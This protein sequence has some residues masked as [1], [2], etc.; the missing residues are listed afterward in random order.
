M[1]RY[2]SNVIFIRYQ[3]ISFQLVA[4]Y[5]FCVTLP[6]LDN[7]I[8]KPINIKKYL[9]FFYVYQWLLL[10][11]PVRVNCII[12][13]LYVTFDY[14]HPVSRKASVII[15][16]FNWEYDLTSMSIVAKCQPLQK[17]YLKGMIPFQAYVEC[18]INP[19]GNLANKSYITSGF[20]SWKYWLEI[21]NSRL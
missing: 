9:T 4:A 17:T 1:K 12:R 19:C 13:T 14:W 3:F 8:L 16:Y 7:S 15:F 6:W 5:V 10:W 2:S 20:S 21:N 18:K 11:L